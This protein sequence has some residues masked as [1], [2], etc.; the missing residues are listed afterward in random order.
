MSSVILTSG[1]IQDDVEVLIG[2]WYVVIFDGHRDVLH[3]LP[4]LIHQHCVLTEQ[5]EIARGRIA[6]FHTVRHCADVV[7]SPGSQN[8]EG[9]HIAFSQSHNG[10]FFKRIWNVWIKWDDLTVV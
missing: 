1:I 5:G 2:L 4:D 6:I 8:T 9:G 7:R 3:P 10:R